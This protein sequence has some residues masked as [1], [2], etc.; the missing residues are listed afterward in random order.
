M[1]IQSKFFADVGLQ[2]SGNTT[3]GG[4]LVVDGNLTVSGTS[5]TVNS[6]TTTIEDSMMELAS[7]NTSSDVLD[8]GFYGNYDD[9]LSDGGASEYTGLFRDASDSTW[10]LYDGLEVEPT[11]T[12]NTSGTGYTL[13]DLLV[14]DLT[15]TTLTATNGLTGSSITYPTS[16]GTSGQAIITDGSGNLSFSTVSGGLDGGSVTTTSTSA[17]NLDT[18]ALNTTRSGKYEVSV[19]DST[20]GDYQFTELSVIHDGTS[21][22][23]SQYGTVLTGS[24]ELATFSVDININTF[25][26]RFTSASTNSTVYKFKKILV[27]V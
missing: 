18:F 22:F 14:G 17:T 20:S 21:A 5:M 16:D 13:A 26:I 7:N 25:R 24:S 4:N 23:I 11:T 3:I 6:T 10:K 9:G 27:D 15:A 12:V 8:I 1:G 19:S 2:T